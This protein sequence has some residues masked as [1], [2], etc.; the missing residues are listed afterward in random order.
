VTHIPIPALRSPIFFAGVN[1]YIAELKK[2]TGIDYL[3]SLTLD[4]LLHPAI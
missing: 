1:T 2:T 3:F 4:W